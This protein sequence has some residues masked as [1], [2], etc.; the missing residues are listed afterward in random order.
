M[1]KLRS[2]LKGSAFLEKGFTNWKDATEG[3]R[4]HEK[5]K[6]HGDAVEV[7]VILPETVRDVGESL[8][9]AHAKNKAENL[10]SITAV[11]SVIIRR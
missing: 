2:S 4:R 11:I 9:S 10:R 5:S 3:F 8:S 1:G 6:C 7:M